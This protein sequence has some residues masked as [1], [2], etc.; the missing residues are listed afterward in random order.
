MRLPTQAEHRE[1]H[2]PYIVLCAHLRE[3]RQR[4]YVEHRDNNTLERAC[5]DCAARLYER[6]PV[7]YAGYWYIWQRL[8]R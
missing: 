3:G 6:D 4:T 2:D 1:S 7:K 5:L 8:M